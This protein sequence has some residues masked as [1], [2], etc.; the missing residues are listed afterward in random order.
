MQERAVQQ[1]YDGLHV[2]YD[3]GL[4]V[5]HPGIG[6]YHSHSTLPEV[7]SQSHSEV[8]QQYQL[9]QLEKSKSSYQGS[10][11]YQHSSLA[12][13][14]VSSVQVAPGIGLLG[15]NS[16]GKRERILCM[17]RKVFFAVLAIAILLIVAGIAAGV[18]IGLANRKHTSPSSN[19]PFPSTASGNITCPSSDALIYQVADTNRYFEIICGVDYAADDGAVDL[20]SLPTYDMAGCIEACAMKPGCTAAGWGDY[21]NRKICFLKK[22]VQSSHE[23]SG[24][25]FTKEVEDPNKKAG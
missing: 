16:Q 18:G 7:S 6:A 20:T 1:P 8:W 14:Q 13:T 2:A 9:Q 21:E 15:E 23:V 10:N 24:W 11:L 22:S 25:M 17:K 19:L 4:E 5:A 12:P 3:N